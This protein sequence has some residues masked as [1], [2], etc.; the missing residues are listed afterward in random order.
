MLGQF[1]KKQQGRELINE[2]LLGAEL[3]MQVKNQKIGLGPN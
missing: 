3:V 1:W 2:E